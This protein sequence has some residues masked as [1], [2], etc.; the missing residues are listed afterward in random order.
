MFFCGGGSSR[1]V[2]QLCVQV[3]SL[4]PMIR[5]LWPGIRMGCSK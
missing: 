3:L 5:P 2:T 1:V 4:P